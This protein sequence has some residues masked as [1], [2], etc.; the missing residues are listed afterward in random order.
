MALQIA[1][2]SRKPVIRTKTQSAI[3]QMATVRRTL[4]AA[5]NQHK[6]LLARLDAPQARRPLTKL[7]RHHQ[8]EL[9]AL[10]QTIQSLI[11]GNA[12]TAKIA[13]IITSAPDAGPVLAA[14]LIASMPELGSM[15]S[16]QAAS[17][18]GVAPHPRQSQNI[19]EARTVPGR[20][21]Q[22]QTRSLHGHPERVQGKARTALPLLHK[23]QRSWKT[24][25]GR[26]RRRHEKVHRLAQRHA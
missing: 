13:G 21:S 26:D 20:Q 17:L 15:S 9:K 7:L 10:N 3:K 23:T 11:A 4:I 1:V 16:R 18:V 5:I 8:R 2:T 24:V 6:S 14:E 25:Q 12:H 22:Y 19:R